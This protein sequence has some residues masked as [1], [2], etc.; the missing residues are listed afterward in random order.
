MNMDG[1]I[2]EF[3]SCQQEVLWLNSIAKSLEIDQR[4]SESASSWH[5]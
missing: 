4:T 1:R 3:G 2:E 5:P